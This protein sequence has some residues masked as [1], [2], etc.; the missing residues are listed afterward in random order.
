VIR[1]LLNIAPFSNFQKIYTRANLLQ[2]TIFDLIQ[3][4]TNQVDE[5]KRV[6]S[7]MPEDVE[8]AIEIYPSDISEDLDDGTC[9]YYM[10]DHSNRVLFWISDFNADY[11]IGEI[12]GVSEPMH[13]SM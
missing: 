13:I 9:G 10:V 3:K 11:L 4:L 8:Y 1:L 5:A 2:T 6:I 7:N 12:D